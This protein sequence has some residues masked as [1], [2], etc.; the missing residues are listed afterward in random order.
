MAFVS[1]SCSSSCGE[2]S[3]SNN[4]STS[5]NSQ[6]SENCPATACEVGTNLCDASGNVRE[7][8]PSDQDS[9]CG[10]P[11]E[12]VESCET[13]TTCY[14]GQCAEGPD[15]AL[16]RTIDEW[17]DD[18]G[19]D[20]AP[21]TERAYGFFSAAHQ[22]QVIPYSA[23]EAVMQGRHFEEASSADKQK[24]V[25]INAQAN[26]VVTMGMEADFEE[27][28]M[29]DGSL[30]VVVRDPKLT[31]EG[32]VEAEQFFVVAGQMSGRTSWVGHN[33]GFAASSAGQISGG[34]IF[35]SSR[36]CN[37][38]E[39][40]KSC[41]HAP[42]GVGPLPCG[43]GVSVSRRPICGPGVVDRSAGTQW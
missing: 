6:R 10:V 38:G 18:F 20:Y 21:L 15:L 25:D 9:N 3:L 31:P 39:P 7:C 30:F 40:P 12:D 33:V 34:P 43:G 42:G 23:F 4:M 36:C 19:T 28:E 22:A 13:G 24:S 17:N 37:G 26:D 11:S 14:F 2:D 41:K 35:P 1:S 8:V 32:K 5:I 29:F 27:A 16:P